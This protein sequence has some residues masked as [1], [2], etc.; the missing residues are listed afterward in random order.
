MNSN[1]YFKGLTV[2]LLLIV[3]ASFVLSSCSR[4]SAGGE[5]EDRT[6]STIFSE[7]EKE[8]GS[9]TKAAD[10]NASGDNDPVGTNASVSYESESVQSGGSNLTASTVF[11][12]ATEKVQNFRSDSS[13]S[14]TVKNTVVNRCLKI[15]SVGESNGVLCAAVKNVSGKDIEYCV[16]KCKIGN[17]EAVFTFSVLP[18][19]QSSVACEQNNLKYEKNTEFSLWSIESRVDYEQG[20]SLYEDVF[21][22]RCEGNY[23]EIKNKTEND[24]DGKIKICCKNLQNESLYTGNAYLISAD[25]LK[26]GETKQLFS[27]YLNAESSRVIYIEYDK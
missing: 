2:F 22:I 20:F 15:E 9:S 19:N 3:S 12:E 6:A 4:S 11:E 25:G 1:R 27:K 7:D 16:L 13:A 21:D 17:G 24:I 5:A 8:N 14:I 10:A 18:E 23:I 26:K